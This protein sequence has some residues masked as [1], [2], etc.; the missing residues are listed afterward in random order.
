MKIV[1][2]RSLESIIIAPVFVFLVLAGTGLYFLVSYSVNEFA[3]RSI[4][5][6]LSALSEA[7]YEEADKE[8]DRCDFRGVVC[9]E[10]TQKTYHQLGVFLRFENFA[11]QNDVAILV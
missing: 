6:N 9:L 8:I 3:D 7:A 11:R 10:G 4:K 2:F 1:Y 5:E